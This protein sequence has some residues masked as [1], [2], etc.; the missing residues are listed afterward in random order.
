LS[1][2]T[3][4]AGLTPLRTWATSVAAHV[5]LEVPDLEA[6]REFYCGL[7]GFEEVSYLHSAGEMLRRLMNADD[8]SV[9]SVMLRVPGGIFIELQRY[10]PQG[11]VGA[12]ALNNQGL[13]HM[14]FA[15]EDVRAE[16]ARLSAA[17][18]KFAGEPIDVHLDDHPIDGH[19]VVYFEDPWGLPIELMGPT[20]VA[21][22]S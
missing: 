14:C 17:G 21:Q 1:G 6:A 12:N 18:V 22:P 7:L 10:T 11:T 2:A 15:V 3:E 20:V 19:T 5:G 4:K 9:E 16:F 8:A 13:T